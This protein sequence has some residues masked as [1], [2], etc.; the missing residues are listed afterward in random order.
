MRTTLDAKQVT[1]M[2]PRKVAQQ[3][4]EALPHLGFTAGMAF[5][6]GIGGIADHRQHASLAQRC[7]CRLIGSR[8][9]QRLRVKFPVTGMQQH[10]M[11]RIDHQRLRLGDGMRDAQ[12]LQPERRQIDRAAGGTTCNFT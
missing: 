12:E 9:D 10:A 11:R 5:H 2:R 6:H 8:P 7:Q 4:R 3:R 1:A